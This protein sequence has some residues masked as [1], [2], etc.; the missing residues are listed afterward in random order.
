M[1]LYSSEA[2][3]ASQNPSIFDYAETMRVT[4]YKFYTQLLRGTKVLHSKN[5]QNQVGHLGVRLTKIVSGQNIWKEGISLQAREWLLRVWRVTLWIDTCMY[6][7]ASL[8]A[9]IHWYT[10]DHARS[11]QI[12]KDL[13]LISIRS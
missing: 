1:F 6:H 10:H 2:S 12:S 4:V 11:L 3:D 7:S 8:L 5:H 9:C 13:N